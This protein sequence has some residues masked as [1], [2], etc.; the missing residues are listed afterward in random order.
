MLGWL[1]PTHTRTMA[2]NPIPAVHSL[3]RR[4]V[5]IDFDWQDA[6]LLPE[7]LRRP[8]VSVRLVAG[9]RT[10]DPGVRVA[11]LCGLPRTFDLADLTREI[12]DLALVG[13]RSSRRT[14]L[15]SLLLA[16]G[17]PCQTPQ[18]FL[19][20]F[21][22]EAE[23][24][25]AIEAPLALHAA[26]LEHTLGGGDFSA[27]LQQALPDIGEGAPV[28]P[29][30]VHRVPQATVRVLS[31]ED[32]PSRESRAHLERA[33]KDL[34]NMSGAGTAELHAGNDAS[35]QLVAQVGPEDKLL[36]GLIDLA[37]ELGTPQVGTRMSEPGKGRAW[38]AWPFQT[39]QR[40]GVLAAA[41]IDP[42][43][44]W[45]RWQEMV[46]DLRT[47]WDEEDRVKASASFPFTPLRSTGWLDAQE[48]SRHIDLSV[49]RHRSDRMRFELHRLEFPDS[50]AAVDVMCGW[51][52][53]QLRDM[54]CVTRPEQR[55]ILLLLAGTPEG[56]A[57]VRRRL[58]AL[59]D[60]AWRDVGGGPPAPSLVDQH[61]V[62]AGPED[63]EAFLAA[64]GAW[65]E[66]S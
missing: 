23:V 25:P 4:V 33:L 58:L 62:L 57:H 55:S 14:Q 19:K 18:E 56:F 26:T 21:V 44:G 7:L 48:F 61:V 37:H 40:R 36:R 35:L 63:V 51:L 39:T 8:G 41:A 3:P 60:T 20:G 16:L 59:W 27:L 46:E 43:Q 30:P 54:D 45:A 50:P 34:V 15:E 24:H 9:E 32:F 64:A 29:E 31:M 47:T 12:F 1:P 5:L 28:T 42:E 38:G 10:E 52:P 53:G 6:D 66:R 22:S 65:L 49:E 11:E 13:E 2:T 17:T